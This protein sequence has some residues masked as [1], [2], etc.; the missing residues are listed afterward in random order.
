MDVHSLRAELSDVRTAAT[1]AQQTLDPQARQRA[2]VEAAIAQGRAVRQRAAARRTPIAG[3]AGEPVRRPDVR[4][5]AATQAQQTLDRQARQRAA[6]AAAI[7]Q[8]RAVRQSAAARRTPIAGPGGEPVRRPD[9]RRQ[10]DPSRRNGRG[11]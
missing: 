8:G 10:Q 2:A 11:L 6:A 4:Q 7:A 9:V 1:Q 5:S 3:P